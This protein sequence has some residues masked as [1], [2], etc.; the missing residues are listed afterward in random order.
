MGLTKQNVGLLGVVFG[1]VVISTV[2]QIG[3]LKKQIIFPLA[4]MGVLDSSSA[5]V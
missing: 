5:Q 4:P 3:P 1:I 2:G